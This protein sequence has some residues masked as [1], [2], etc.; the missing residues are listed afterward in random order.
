M[1]SPGPDIGGKNR[2]GSA[3]TIQ[4]QP[5]GDIGITLDPPSVTYL[6]R[7]C[8]LPPGM[9]VQVHRADHQW[10]VTVF[11]NNASET[12][13]DGYSTLEDVKTAIESRLHELQK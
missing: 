4:F 13:V 8:G 6:Y 12:W 9:N 1:T 2:N 11:R 10:W 3:M 7:V 5:I